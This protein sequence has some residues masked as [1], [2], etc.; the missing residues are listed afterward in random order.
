MSEHQAVLERRTA[1]AAPPP[2]APR[3]G[4]GRLLPDLSAALKVSVLVNECGYAKFARK[5]V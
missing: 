3:N 1:E 5:I 2:A 4:H